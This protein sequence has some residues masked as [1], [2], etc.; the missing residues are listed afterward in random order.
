LS[1]RVAILPYLDENDLHDRFRYDEPWDSD[2]N[3]EWITKLPQVYR[4]PGSTALPESTVYLTI[5]GSDTVFS[6]K[7]GI[8]FGQIIDGSS[9]TILAV[10]AGDAMAV[11]WTKPDDLLNEAHDSVLGLLGRPDAFWAL[12]A[13]GS[14]NSISTSIGPDTLRALFTRNDK[15]PLDRSLWHGDR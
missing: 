13:D 10:E 5:R 2:D 12:F 11:P 7:Q 9:Y 8:A 15:T 4:S 3:K 6:G 14:V 1:W